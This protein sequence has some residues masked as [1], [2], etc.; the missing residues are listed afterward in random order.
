M[1]VVVRSLKS[2]WDFVAFKIKDTDNEET[3]Q[4]LVA[5]KLKAKE[6]R[7]FAKKCGGEYEAR[8]MDRRA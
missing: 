1:K 5:D 7:A 4:R 8:A 3:L 6:L 2:P